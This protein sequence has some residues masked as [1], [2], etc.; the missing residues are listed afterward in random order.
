M[1]R[2]LKTRRVEFHSNGIKLDSVV[3]RGFIIWI[4]EDLIKD[5]KW[6]HGAQNKTEKEKHTYWRVKRQKTN[7]TSF[8][9]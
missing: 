6:V 4:S 7:G 5:F 2:G 3:N 1:K 8:Y 9:L